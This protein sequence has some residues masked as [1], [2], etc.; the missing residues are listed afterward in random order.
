MPKTFIALPNFIPS[1]GLALP[2][3]AGLFEKSSFKMADS[4]T[5]H[6]S[7]EQIFIDIQSENL[8][9]LSKERLQYYCNTLKLKVSGDKKELTQRLEP[10]AKCKKLFTKKVAGITEDYKFST[11]LDSN[12]IPPPSANW[13]VIGKNKD[14]AV[15]IVTESTIKDYEKAK[16]AGGKGQYRKAYRLFSARR[17]MSV[18]ATESSAHSGA[19]YVKGNILKSYTGS[20]SRPATILFVNN[21]PV[22]AYCGCAVGKSGVCCHV[23]ALLIELNYYHENKK[24]YLHMSCTE[25][26]QKWQK[27]GNSATKRAATQIKLKYL[28]NL[29]GTRRDI[30]KVRAKK[31]VLKPRNDS[32]HSDWYERDV[33][34]ME[35]KLKA[36]L[37]TMKP[38]AE[39][40][41]FSVLSQYKKNSGLFLH[42]RYKAELEK[43]QTGKEY[44]RD[45][46]KPRFG[47]STESV[48]RPKRLPESTT[49]SPVINQS[50]TNQQ[51]SLL[52]RVNYVPVDQCTHDWRA[53]RVGI[54]TA[55][56]VPA[57][58]GFCG[59][60]EYDSAWFVIWN[61]IDESILNLKRF[62]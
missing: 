54:I 15:P 13:K 56:K 2:D 7:F 9:K 49:I 10:L 16:Y 28:R 44:N 43:K 42:L 18:K 45:V 31:K 41:F 53:L 47:D 11:A 4:Q 59:M 25:K 26:L 27:K 29:R 51:P 58:L 57:L 23:I 6:V 34:K 32:D 33:L 8:D 48:W 61:N 1:G 60:K 35:E 40:H 55:S 17:I 20:V 36:N 38:T 30:K 62:R 5:K 14:V 22:K 52:K 12:L 3:F 24:L 19:L 37:K 39:S 50:A 21:I 46:L